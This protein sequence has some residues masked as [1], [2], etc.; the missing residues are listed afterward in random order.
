MAAKRVRLSSASSDAKRTASRTRDLIPPVEPLLPRPAET[1]AAEEPLSRRLDIRSPPPHHR[2]ARTQQ[3]AV[4]HLGN[5]WTPYDL[6]AP[7][8]G[9]LPLLL[10]P[11]ARQC[12][13]V[14]TV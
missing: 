7:A 5:G 6:P 14:R 8:E 12:R 1:P 13:I 10:S 9:A 11:H 2:A 4:S 3:G